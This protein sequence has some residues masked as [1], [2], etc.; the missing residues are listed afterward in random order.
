[1]TF[2]E[3]NDDLVIPRKPFKVV[4]AIAVH[5]RLPLLEHTIRR[6]YEKNG[7]YKVICAGDG[8]DER[9]LCENMDAVWVFARNKPLGRKWNAA[10]QKAREFN[11][12]AVV[13]VGSSD[14][15]SDNWFYMMQPYVD[16]H[17]FSGVPG[18]YL[19]DLGHQVRLC[20]WTCGYEGYR[21]ER[22]DETI[23]IGRM[24]SRRL[25]DAIDWMP[26]NSE[27][28]NSLD[29]SMKDRS[30]LKG[31]HDFMVHDNRL[32]ALSLSCP[33]WSNK[34]KFFM[35][36]EGLI[37]SIRMDNSRSWLNNNLPEAIE[38][39]KKLIELNLPVHNENS[40]RIRK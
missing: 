33:H 5:G 21:A 30:I 23:G 40:A 34:H 10:F 27:L 37:P 13:F 16:T 18:C 6:L 24:L 14:W 8:Q 29:R 26:F 20:D 11:P 35:H 3:V 2:D 7:C 39:H 32:K 38:L 28:D 31:Y 25:L 15:L 1:M 22:A 12:D 9:S 19:A 36:W 4:A 17:G